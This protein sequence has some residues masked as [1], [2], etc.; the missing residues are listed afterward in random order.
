MHAIE[1]TH[2]HTLR[3]THHTLTHHTLHTTQHTAH[4]TTRYTQRTLQNTQRT[5][6]IQ[7]TP[8][9]TTQHAIQRLRDRKTAP[10]SSA[11]F[12][13]QYLGAEF[14]HI[15]VNNNAKDRTKTDDGHLRFNSRVYIS[16]ICVCH[17][18]F[19][20]SAPACSDKSWVVVF[21]WFM[22]RIST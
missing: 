12:Q 8:N 4:N 2:T 19:F 6:H 18:F 15:G 10:T 5:T 20:R 22:T 21:G 16:I 13:P 11:K 17:A 3:T 9:T 7:H 1:H 14:R